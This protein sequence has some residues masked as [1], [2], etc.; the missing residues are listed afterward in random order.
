MLKSSVGGLDVQQLSANNPL[1]HVDIVDLRQFYHS[2]LGYV[3]EQSISMA[4]ASV[5][6]RLPE[7]R[8]VGL[9]YSVPYLDR[10][11]A[12]TERT[13]AFMPAGQGAVNWP[14]GEPSATA[15]VFDEELPLPDSSVDRV[16]MVH[17]LEFAEN[18]RETLKEIWRVLAPGGRLVI[19]VP[20][21]RGV[22]ARMDHT[23][24]GAGRPYS[25]GQLTALF[26]EANF[27]PGASAEALFFPPSRLK[28]VL[29]MRSVFERFGRVLSP[30]FA[31]VIVV[32]AEKR[33]YQG[34]PVAAKASRRVFVPVLSPQG[35][36]T[37]RTSASPPSTK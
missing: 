20:N 17:S 28:M 31:G 10:F 9:G 4:L 3:A 23:P 19:V 16:L 6:H 18:P 34:L 27:T 30:A 1:M 5:W 36:P 7:E 25:R 22:W 15:L 37:T 24:F 21:R 11:R 26:R 33:L 29:R 12:D 8:L 2:Q 14:P 13:F 35:V 32:E